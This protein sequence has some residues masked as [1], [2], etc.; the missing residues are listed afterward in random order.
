M[1][2]DARSHKNK[3]A[4]SKPTVGKDRQLTKMKEMGAKLGINAEGGLVAQLLVRP[5][6]REQILQAQFRYNEGSK[7]R[8]NLEV[9]VEMPFQIANDGSLI[10]GQWLYVSNKETV[11]RMVL[12]ETHESKFSMHPSSIKMY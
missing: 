10:M 6:Y 3:A 9:G 11:T 4:L 12:R 5:T 8:K 1:V 7:I 2:A